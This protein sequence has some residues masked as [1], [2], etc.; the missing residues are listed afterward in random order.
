MRIIPI[1]RQD[2]RYSVIGVEQAE[3]ILREGGAVSI[4]PEGTPTPYAKSFVMN[5]AGTR[6]LG[7]LKITVCKLALK[8][9][10]KILP[11]WADFEDYPEPSFGKTFVRMVRYGYTMRI[12][13]GERYRPTDNPRKAT[14]ELEQRILQTG[15]AGP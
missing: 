7:R 11:V 13:F 5:D 2:A 14:E 9:G 3:W 1:D 12:W 8:T 6:R 4:F 10:A 15:A